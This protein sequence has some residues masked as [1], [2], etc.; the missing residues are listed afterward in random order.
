[1]R[2]TAQA[3][4]ITL[5]LLVI[6]LI[7]GAYS[8]L[9]YVNSPASAS[10]IVSPATTLSQKTSTIKSTPVTVSDPYANFS[11][12]SIFKPLKQQP[13]TGNILASYGYEH[14]ALLPWQLVVT[15]NFLPSDSTKD[16]SAYYAMSQNPTRYNA[17]TSTVNGN[18]VTTM[19]DLESGGFSKIAFLFHG[20]YSADIS[21]NSDDA[22][23]AS[24]EQ[25]I[26]TQVLQSWQ[27]K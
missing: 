11:Y 7:V 17:L 21:F 27:W 8:F 2:R 3:F 10:N 18:Q 5:S 13:N 26:L 9:R 4:R 19:T 1:M 16:D 23:N 24:E 20:S 12:P 25:A 15:I 6:G 22:Q 14:H